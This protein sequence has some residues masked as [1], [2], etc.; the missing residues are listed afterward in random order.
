LAILG[1]KSL[2][3]FTNTFPVQNKKYSTGQWVNRVEK[4]QLLNT[5]PYCLN[6]IWVNRVYKI[7]SYKMSKRQKRTRTCE[8]AREKRTKLQK[9]EKNSKNEKLVQRR[10]KRTQI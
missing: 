10:G 9:H 7:Q 3:R 5:P 6:R 1:Q 4:P 8:K 2:D